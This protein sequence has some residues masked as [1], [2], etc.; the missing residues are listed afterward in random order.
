MVEQAKELLKAKLA[1]WAERWLL[2][3]RQEYRAASRVLSA[4][5]VTHLRGYFN[6]NFLTRLKVAE[7]GRIPNP[8]FFP[9]LPSMG[10]PIPWDY[11]AD[12]SLALVDTVIL[13]RPLVPEGDWLS[14]L[15]RECVHIQQFQTL[16]VAKLIRRYVNGLFMN[17]FN[18]SALPMERQARELQLRYDAGLVVFSVEHEVEQ[19][20]LSGAI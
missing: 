19:A 6:A 17:G 5:E 2:K 7:S 3:L 16:G 8:S 15:F 11:S 4:D 18:Y 10:L 14:V 13:H 12:P 20:V 9:D 1:A